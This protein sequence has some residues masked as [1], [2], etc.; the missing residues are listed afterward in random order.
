[1]S[2]PIPDF[3]WLRDY[4]QRLEFVTTTQRDNATT[5]IQ[6]IFPSIR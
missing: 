1:M 6:P 3:V 2:T 4:E 5:A